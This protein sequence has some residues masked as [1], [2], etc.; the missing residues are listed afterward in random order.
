MV[1]FG[2]L[3]SATPTAL[4][5]MNGSART[6]ATFEP[7]GGTAAHFSPFSTAAVSF[8]DLETATPKALETMS[9]NLAPQDVMCEI[10]G[11]EL[12]VGRSYPVLLGRRGSNDFG[13]CVVPGKLAERGERRGGVKFDA[14]AA[15]LRDREIFIARQQRI[16]DRGSSRIVP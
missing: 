4:A 7:F 8:G 1:S 12:M 13:A 3:D 16:C 14:S 11:D 2:D 9:A 10:G 6:E 15:A 5:S